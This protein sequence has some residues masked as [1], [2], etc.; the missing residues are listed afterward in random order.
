[1][2]FGKIYSLLLAATMFTSCSEDSELWNTQ[3]ATISMEQQELTFKENRGIVNVPIVVEGERNGAI[4]VT[5]EVAETGTNP[6]MDDI[7]YLV[8]SKTIVI[9]ADA[10]VGQIELSTVDDMDINESRT[11]T[12][13]I[14]QVDGGSIGTA[15]TTS[16]ILSDNDAAFYEKLMGKWK[17]QAANASSGA[18]V[19][20]DVTIVGYEEGEAGYDKTLYITGIEG[21]AWTQLELNYSYDMSTNKVSLTIPMGTLFAGEVDF[22]LANL[23]N[24]LASSIVD[25]SLAIDS[26]FDIPGEVNDDFT[27][28]TFQAD[29]VLAGALFDSVTDAFSGSV[30]F[31]YNTIILTRP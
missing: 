17:F 18:P 29:R 28:I 20:Y 10:T 5:V 7:H 26:E 2:K 3:N 23:Q 6:A 13:T 15:K 27:T 9:P 30:W 25:G 1:M 21:Y 22:G 14:S 24:V 12:M 19:S 31:R 16:L 11:F 4:R 8:T